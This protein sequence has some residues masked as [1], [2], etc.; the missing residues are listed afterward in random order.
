MRMEAELLM[1]GRLRYSILCIVVLLHSGIKV[2][3]PRLFRYGHA[4][5]FEQMRRMRQSHFFL[6]TALLYF[7]RM[8]FQLKLST[9]LPAVKTTF[10]F[11]PMSMTA[12]ASM[13]HQNQS[14]PMVQ[15]VYCQLFRHA[16]FSRVFTASWQ[17][18]RVLILIRQKCG[19]KA[20]MPC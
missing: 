15:Q 12:L 14:G 3:R 16:M 2:N 6:L 19:E 9:S 10:S 8:G 18:L 7:P 11:Q 4:Y 5:V 17:H 20:V 1:Q 13:I